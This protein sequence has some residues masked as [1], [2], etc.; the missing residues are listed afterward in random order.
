M[1]GKDVEIGVNI[2]CKMAIEDQFAHMSGKYFDNDRRE[3]AAPHPDALNSEKSEDIVKIIE[4]LLQE[5]V[6]PV[7]EAAGRGRM[8]QVQ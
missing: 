4:E 8:S 3:F 2:L 1:S 7:R 6:V 5:H